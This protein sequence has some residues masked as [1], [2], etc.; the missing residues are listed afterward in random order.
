MVDSWRN[1]I[2]KA[3]K[4]AIHI[5]ERESELLIGPLEKHPRELDTGRINGEKSCCAQGAH[6]SHS[7]PR[8]MRN[9]LNV[10]IFQSKF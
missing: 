10:F 2:G 7:F 8:K 6:S 9:S 1:A 5:T 3:S 4:L